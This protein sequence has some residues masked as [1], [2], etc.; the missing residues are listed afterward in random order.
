MYHLS[1]IPYPENSWDHRINDNIGTKYLVRF[2][3][4]PY[5]K[6]C[7]IS[8]LKDFIYLCREHKWGGSSEEEGESQADPLPHPDE[9]GA[10]C[11]SP[12]H[13]PEIMT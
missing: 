6:K 4:L 11:R 7:A 9:R 10:Q 3:H 2:S 13:A 12:S 5:T 8:F 1:H